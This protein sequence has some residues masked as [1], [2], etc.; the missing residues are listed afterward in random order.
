MDKPADTTA[1][2]HD[3][4]RRRWSPRAF[5]DREVTDDELRTLLEAARWAPSSSNE[6]P[7]RFIVAPRRDRD[8][9]ARALSCLVPANQVWAGGAA[10]LMLT[11]T[12]TVFARHGQ[13]NAH[14]WHDVG[15]AVA[16]MSIQAMTM[17]LFVHQMAG[18][19]PAR[20]RELYALPESV[21]PVTAI[22]LG[23]PGDPKSLPEPLAG[24][25]AG[26]RTRKP[27]REFVFRDRYGDAS[28]LAT[29]AALDR[30]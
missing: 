26:P 24:R 8:A 11:C 1:P 18:I 17:D 25:E 22:A 27:L 16:T 13:R 21:E 9:F 5:A 2:L 14:A 30:R 7:W 10:V 20:V 6:Q 23:H 19:D 29:E 4:I 12:S 28:P 15:L 3:P